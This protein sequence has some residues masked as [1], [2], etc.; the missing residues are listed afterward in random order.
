MKEINLTKIPDRDIFIKITKYLENNKNIIF[1][2]KFEGL[3][4]IYWDFKYND[5]YYSLRL[6]QYFG[7]TIYTDDY[8][9]NKIIN[10]LFKYI[11]K[12]K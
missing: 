5:N 12:I 8:N 7:I 9:S 4:E 2:N 3:D 6:S 1:Y 10:K 11:K